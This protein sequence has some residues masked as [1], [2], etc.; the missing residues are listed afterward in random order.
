M[1]ELAILVISVL[2]SSLTGIFVF[3]RNP[4]HIINRLYGLLTFSL[5]VFSIS[6][7]LSLQTVD[8]LWYIRVVIS[9][10]ALVVASLYF[11]I[12]LLNNPDRPLTRWQSIGAYYTVIV[13]VL[14]L[15]PIVFSG[16]KGDINPVPV[17]NVGAPLFIIHL[18]FFMSASFVLLLKRI[19][20]SKGSEKVQYTY[21][22][23]GLLPLLMLS[24]VT[25]VLMPV[26][27]GNPSLVFVSPVYTAILVCCIG[28]AI[29]RHRLFD[30]RIIVARSL[31]YAASLLF[32]ATV[33]GFVVFGISQLAFN[34]HLSFWIQAILSLATGLAA[35]AFQRFKVYFDRLTNR[36]FYQDAYD[37]QILFDEYNKTLVSTIDLELLMRRSAVVVEKYLKSEYCALAVRNI[38]IT[39]TYHRVGSK[40]NNLTVQLLTELQSAHRM[41]E[42]VIV[43]D[44]LGV[45][46]RS[47]RAAMQESA[48]TLIVRLTPNARNPQESLGYMVLGVKKSGNPYN[49]Q[50]T[51]VLETL[52]N[53]LVIALQNALR[54]EEIERFNETLQQRV[55]D[56]T[57]QLRISNK[58]LK[59]LNETKDDFIGMASHQ[60]RTPLTAVK[61]YV[62]LV[63]DGDA[64][65][66]NKQQ[67]ELLRQAFVSSQRMV[68][69]I[70]DLLNVSRIK[71]GKFNIERAPTNVSKLISDEL[72]QLKATAASRNIELQFQAPDSFPSLSLDETKTRQVIMNFIDNAIYYTPAGG[73]IKVELDESPMSIELRVIDD[74]IGVPAAERHQLWAKFYRAKNAQRARPD[75]TGLGLY[76]AKKVITAQGGAII[77]DSKEGQGS[78][79]GFTFPKDLPT[80]SGMVRT[81]G[82]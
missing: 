11:L 36:L 82:S 3:A 72:A 48:A 71:T 33:Y 49:G 31:A 27:L 61:G 43:A 53:E 20:R 46:H 67:Y 30:V 80:E 54:F 66:I 28:Y 64:G 44:N 25:G 26:I 40:P 39:D 51:Q 65:K 22:L 59:D 6:N 78:T 58:K 32:V 60:L 35:L 4:R 19:R 2:V 17:P 68:Y 70:A 75:G 45:E 14:N 21:F 63:M 34:I 42:M 37:S 79:F 57:R 77:F 23:V 18:L 47:L 1:L 12:L 55:D 81:V 29:V 62:S 7:Y 24:P 56:A 10:T 74:G 15:T 38:N 76:M 13:A 41:Q 69:L 5:I 73:H 50:D 9:F 16:L 52:G 8:R